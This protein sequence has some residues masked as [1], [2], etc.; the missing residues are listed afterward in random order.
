MQCSSLTAGATR[1]QLVVPPV[2]RGGGCYQN[3]PALR[4]AGHIEF[5]MAE[6]VLHVQE[7]DDVGKDYAFELTP[8]W[9][10]ATLGE[11]VQD[12]SEERRSLP[13]GG[14]LRPDPSHPAGAVRV[15]AQQNGDEYLVTGTISAHLL[16]EC[17]RCLGPAPLAV[18]VEFATLFTR[19]SSKQMP[20]ELELSEEDLQREEFTGNE[21]ALDDLVRE[22]LVLE[23]PMQP[24]CTPDCRGISMPESVRPPEEVF[25]GAGGIDPRLAP[26]QSL[27]D[28]LPPKRNN[29][30]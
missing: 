25:G 11:P 15:H 27:R 22:H 12:G 7:I 21:I 30:E 3:P 14:V 2:L 26:L 13:G 4:E 24:L 28:K 9:L 16:T 1:R 20:A 18:D 23:V 17:G 5:A 10:S 29:K 19:T 6:L 8:A